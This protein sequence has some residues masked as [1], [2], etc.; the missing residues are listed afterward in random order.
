MHVI[1]IQIRTSTA[2]VNVTQ[3]N[4]GN[5]NYYNILCSVFRYCL[6]S[7]IC[8]NNNYANF[9][10]LEMGPLLYVE[11]SHSEKKMNKKEKMEQSS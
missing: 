7:F 3:M 8:L 4:I 2:L 10:F 5:Q 1:C 6:C 9:M 11:N